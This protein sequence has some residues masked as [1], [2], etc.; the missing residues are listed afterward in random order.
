MKI[1]LRSIRE[2]ILLK[3]KNIEI[4]I[5]PVMLG[6]VILWIA[7]GQFSELLNV[8]AAVIIHETAHITVAKI[9]GINTKK[10]ELY[11]FGGSAYMEGIEKNAVYEGIIAFAG[12]A[13]SVMLGGLC[14]YFGIFLRLKQ[15]TYSVALINIL[16]IYPLDG[17]RVAGCV[18]KT[19]W[20]AKKG[21][22]YLHI[23]SITIA[24]M[25]GIFSVYRLVFKCD[26]SYT[27]MSVFM[28]I[29]TL[30]PEEAVFRPD[31][32]IEAIKEAE[33]VK[34]IKAHENETVYC[35]SKRFTGNN[36]HIVIVN[37]K[38]ENVLGCVSETD[39]LDLLMSDSTQ[40]LSTV[41]KCR[42]MMQ[43]K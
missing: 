15:I 10:I 9:L 30:R 31:K 28:I 18:F 42:R 27:V 37:D 35:V 40:N 33:N 8:L 5:S 36:Y 25:F 16:P 14:D 43:G 4:S 2:L 19:I 21:R 24:I 1:A 23:S 6:C 29:A 39:M 22:K 13:A 12:P 26:G 41:I 32:R 34:I 38:N 17:G 11:P 7:A 20:G 3:I